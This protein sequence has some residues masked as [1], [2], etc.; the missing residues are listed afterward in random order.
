MNQSKLIHP[1]AIIL[2]VT[3]L[4]IYRA[5]SFAF[6]LWW[7]ATASQ[8]ELAPLPASSSLIA[9]LDRQNLTALAQGD[10]GV[11]SLFAITGLAE[12]ESYR[13]ESAPHRRLSEE[14]LIWAGRRISGS[15]GDQAMFY[16]ATA[17]LNAL[18]VCPDALMPYAE[19]TDPQREPSAE[20]QAMARDFGQR[21]QIHWIKRWSLEAPLDEN[22]LLDI[23]RA[24]VAGH[25]VACGMRW[26]KKPRGSELLEVPGAE[27]V[28]DGHSVM[29]VG[30]QD[31]PAVKGGGMLRFR[32][33]FGADW[34]DHG[35]GAI[36]YAYAAAYANDAVWLSLGKP[37]SETPAVRY[38]AEDL[39]VTAKEQCSAGPQKMNGYGVKMWSGGAQ[40]FCGAKQG[41]WVELEFA[42]PES[43]R[44]RLRA[45]ATAAP[46]FGMVQAA[47]DEEKLSP[48]FDLY[49]GRVS[50]AGSLELGEHELTQGAHRLRISA[51]GKNP[52]SQGYSFGVDTV[53]LMHA[54][55]AQTAQAKAE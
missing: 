14:Y 51:V 40:L 32:N 7:L 17:G 6:A 50:P 45:L 10:R 19:S 13:D 53:D 55:V 33:S 46:D 27:E 43:G 48:E 44:Y 42:A 37:G 4:Q 23:K 15:H 8:A 35:Y 24:L 38:E 34:G 47:L 41:G 36:S 20:A 12:V 21:W 31:D 1:F 11:C 28:F 22:Q 49:C 9:D 3:N 26:P 16:I 52:F 30:Y 39:K 54:E 2:H 29:L 25:P 5:T 18:G